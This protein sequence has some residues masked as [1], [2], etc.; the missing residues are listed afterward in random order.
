[1]PSRSAQAHP[2]KPPRGLVEAAKKLHGW[3]PLKPAFKAR[4][5]QQAA[6]NLSFAIAWAEMA[7]A[8]AGEPDA[9]WLT[10]A[11]AEMKRAASLIKTL[12]AEA[13]RDAKGWDSKA[14]KI[15]ELF[16]AVLEMYASGASASA[17]TTRPV[18]RRTWTLPDPEP[19]TDPVMEED[20]LVM[21]QAA[22]ERI[23]LREGLAYLLSLTKYRFAGIW[24]FERGDQ[25]ALT[26]YDRHDPTAYTA[27]RAAES[28]GGCV[29]V[30][31]RAGIKTLDE[32]LGAFPDT[33]KRRRKNYH[34][35]PIIG[36]DGAVLATLCLHDTV[37]RSAIPGEAQ[38]LKR[39]AS[40]LAAHQWLFLA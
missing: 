5:L 15:Q 35:V 4:R 36:H 31:T 9:T 38:L 28:C 27:N 37:A 20:A 22:V 26:Y 19:P 21:F 1:M 17:A 7:T 30:R 16:V 25:K 8:T 32:L 18:T 23:G 24:Y 6:E 13:E 12:T 40:F 3:Q 33:D 10:Q 2:I 34:S 11:V 14:P 39:V 29:H